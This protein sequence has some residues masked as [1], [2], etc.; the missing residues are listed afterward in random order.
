MDLKEIEQLIADGR[1]AEAEAAIGNAGT[2][3]ALYLRG[4]I[5]WKRGDRAAAISA[6]NAAAEADPEGPGAIALEQ[7]RAIMDFFNHDLYNP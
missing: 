6:Y 2:P 5:A 7:A 4:R 1:I 3:E